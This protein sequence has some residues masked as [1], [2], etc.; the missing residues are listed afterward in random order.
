[1]IRRT[2]RNQDEVGQ[3][4]DTCLEY[5]ANGSRTVDSVIEQYPEH[6]ESL[7]PP[8][9]AALWLQSRS[10]VFN[11][12]P[13][14][15]KLSK[16]RLVDRFRSN[17]SKSAATALETISRIP[18]F[19]QGHRVAVQYSA[20]LTLTAVLLFVGFQSTSF[21]VQRSIPGDPLYNTKL[22]QENLRVSLSFDD[23]Q[24]VLLRIEFAQRRVIEMQ[25]LIL[26]DRHWLL[27]ETLENFEFQIAEAA[28]G[29]L[30]IA[31][32]DEVKAAEM[33]SLF[34]E[35]LTLPMNNLVGIVDASPG[36]ASAEFVQMLNVIATD[37][38]DIQP[39]TPWVAITTVSPTGTFT[40]TFTPSPTEAAVFA[41]DVV[42]YPTP[43]SSTFDNLVPPPSVQPSDPPFIKIRPTS[44]PAPTITPTDPPAVK[45][46]PTDIPTPT[47]S[48]T[49]EEDEGQ[50]RDKPKKPKKP[51]PTRRPPNPHRPPSKKGE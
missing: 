33:S 8:L 37:V 23:E 19:F 31:K 6:A 28:A 7:R 17:N 25:E 32:T 14:F 2:A 51:K 27:D 40:Y 3:I 4:L 50:G 24:E 49:P 29:I 11:P 9:E 48:P 46:K 34:E 44:T 35:T 47:P 38:F 36:M 41:P 22:S 21:L 45:E 26:T 42:A 1:M 13:G 16:R 12:R 39:F 43:T 10:E 5:I 15:V 20:L 30:A 18:A